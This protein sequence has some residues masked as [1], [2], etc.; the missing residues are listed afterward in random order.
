MCCGHEDVDAHAAGFVVQRLQINIMLQKLRDMEAEIRA[1]EELKQLIDELS[2]TL[3]WKEDVEMDVVTLKFA[4][5]DTADF[6]YDDY[7]KQEIEELLRLIDMITKTKREEIPKVN[8]LIH[9]AYERLKAC[10]SATQQVTVTDV[11]RIDVNKVEVNKINTNSIT[12]N[13]IDV[14]GVVVDK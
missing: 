5:E 4:I 9:L 12:V 13:K 2:A 14:S 3:Y 1:I 6:L 7:C 8:Y 10:I 11:N